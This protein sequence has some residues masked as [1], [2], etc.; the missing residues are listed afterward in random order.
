M[1]IPFR[2][3]PMGNDQGQDVPGGAVMGVRGC[4]TFLQNG[5]C[6]QSAMAM[7]G[8]TLRAGKIYSMAVSSQGTAQAVRIY[9]GASIRIEGGTASGVELMSSATLNMSGGTA[10]GI[11]GGYSCNINITQGEAHGI[12]M[13]NSC[14][15]NMIG[16]MASGVAMDGE[17]AN[18]YV[19]SG[20]VLQ[21]CQMNN[22]SQYVN[23]Q[24]GGTASGLIFKSGYSKTLN[25]SS[26]GT[27]RNVSLGEY[28]SFYAVNGADIAGMTM[29]GSATLTVSSGAAVTGIDM[30]EGARI[31]IYPGGETD[32][33][34]RIEGTGAR[35]SFS[36]NGSHISNVAIGLGSIGNY[37]TAEDCQFY[38]NFILQ[39][40]AMA[41][42]TTWGPHNSS[43]YGTIYSKCR[44]MDNKVMSNM[45]LYVVNRGYAS[46][47]EVSQYGTLFVS[48]ASAAGNTIHSGARLQANQNAQIADVTAGGSVYIEANAQLAQATIEG[49]VMSVNNFGTV[50]AATLVS[51]GRAYIM[52]GG[53]ID[54]LY[55]NGGAAILYDDYD[56]GSATFGPSGGTMY[57]SN[58]KPSLGNTAYGQSVALAFN[59]LAT[60]HNVTLGD[61]G[62]F[63]M[64]Y[65]GTACDINLG[66]GA[67]VRIESG[68]SA[69]DIS[70][71]E[72]GTYYEQFCTGTGSIAVG[73]GGHLSV[74]QH[75]GEN[76]I[77][78]GESGFAE[79]YNANQASVA[80]GSGATFNLV[81]GG[82]A[83]N[84]GGGASGT[85][86]GRG[87][88]TVGIGA[89]ASVVLSSA[90]LDAPTIAAGATVRPTYYATLANA[91]IGA[92]AML[93][94]YG[95]SN[96]ATNVTV[97]DGAVMS[98]C[99]RNSASNVTVQ[100]GGSLYC[101]GYSAWVR[102]VTSEAGAIITGN[103]IYYNE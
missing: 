27:A 28:M 60:V 77:T 67:S 1:K 30:A 73:S 84:I 51:S 29:G 14:N 25:V 13:G 63:S 32:D 69:Q 62:G 44:A 46:G 91:S 41:T 70:L 72:G 39:A 56:L 66:A 100:S 71:G 11:D 65:G 24:S 48:N 3:N 21:D 85:M 9:N 49:G 86:Y 34:F 61:G 97:G 35:G 4:F 23:I 79:I 26:G 58:R 22:S 33:R 87:Y 40:G 10:S 101:D 80:I 89:G 68:C 6:N 53:R 88:A 74:Y 47:N 17:R 50:T 38:Q 12:A 92:G 103:S 20:A 5:K 54:S 31:N 55:I 75:S 37:G 96:Y 95:G 78:V 83:V 36:G 16:G 42:R 19:S 102:G 64:Q 82:T 90:T 2:Y 81:N 57:W 94:A 59:T 8:R 43:A 15:L 45:R 52:N 76:G 93:V 7:S 99:S 98:I 18:I